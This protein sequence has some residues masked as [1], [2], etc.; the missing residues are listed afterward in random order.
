MKKKLLTLVIFALAFVTNSFGQEA[1]EPSFSYTDLS[2]D[3]LILMSVLGVLVIVIVLLLFQMIY[4][5]SFMTAVFKKENPEYANEPSWWESF[6]EKFVTGKV[7][8]AYG[9]A[10]EAKL[11]ADHSYDGIHELDNFMPPWLQ[12]V[13]I[14]TIVFAVV[15][16]TNY[17]VLGIG[18]TGIEEYEEELRLEAIAAEERNANML[19]SIDEST[20]V[21]DESSTSMTGGKTIFEANCAACHAQDGGGGVG[22]NLT[23]DYWIHGG[24]ISDIFTVV[25]YGVIEKGMVPWEDQLSPEEMQQVSSYIFAMRG[26]TPAAPKDPQGELYVPEDLTEETTSDST[27]VSET[28]EV[29]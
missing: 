23:D 2:S 19:A 5:M 27:A 8:E 13:F 18:K 16:F 22:P 24:S 29:E 9:E 10:E 4:L 6:K 21:F 25:K 14:G 28:A 17:T 15:Y 26:T 11:M 20:V 12:Y 1:S 7:D 3:Q